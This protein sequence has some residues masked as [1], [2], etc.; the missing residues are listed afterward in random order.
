MRPVTAACA[1]IATNL[2]YKDLDIVGYNYQEN[3]Y[4]EDHAQIRVA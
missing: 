1:A 4:K 2:W 3:R